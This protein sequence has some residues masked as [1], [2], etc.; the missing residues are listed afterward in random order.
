MKHKEAGSLGFVNSKNSDSIV[1]KAIE[2]HFAPEFIN[3]IHRVVVF[4][5]LDRGT[6]GIVNLRLYDLQ[7]RVLDS[8]IPFVITLSDEAKATLLAEAYSERYGAR[9]VEQVIDARIV[10]TISKLVSSG[11]L[12]KHCTLYISYENDTFTF[13]KSESESAPNV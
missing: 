7:K 2:K 4:K 10:I 5:S 6:V 13:T 11:Q 8:K 1:T 3:R 12:P 9:E